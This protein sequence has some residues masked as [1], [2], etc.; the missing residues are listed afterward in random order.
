VDVGQYKILECDIDNQCCWIMLA[1]HGIFSA[2]ILFS[3]DMNISQTSPVSHGT[4]LDQIWHAAAGDRRYL[5]VLQCLGSGSLDSIFA[6]SD[7]ALASVGAAGLALQ[8]LLQTAGVAQPG[9][10]QVVADRRLASLWFSGTIRPQGWQ[11]PSLWDAV[12]G[13][14][15]TA[16]GWIRL[17]TNAPHHRAAALA[18]LGVAADKAA[19][20]QAVQDWSAEA[21]EAAVVAQGGCAAAMRTMAQWQVHPQG[22]AVN[23]EPLLHWTVAA[24]SAVPDWQ[25]LPQRPLQGIRVLDLTRVLAGPTAT[26]FLAGFGAQVLRIDPPGWDEPGVVPDMTVGKQCARVDLHTAAGRATFGELLAQAD[27]LVHGYRA[28][29]LDGLGFDAGQRRR[30]NPGLVDVSLNA[31]GWSGPW[32]HRRGFDSLV[33]MSSGIAEAGMQQL[34]RTRPTPLPVQALDYACG[35]LLATAAIRGLTQ[36]LQSG[37]GVTAQT[38]LARMAQLLVS[39]SG[40][41]VA[42]QGPLVPESA[43]DLA[44][45][46]EATHWGA[47]QRLR[48]PV[49]LQ[50]AAGEIEA[51]MAWQLPAMPLGSAAPRW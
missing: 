11:L 18:V 48:G 4:F 46:I 42:Q 16:D 22:A 7:L 10:L 12:A 21:L 8:E 23:R 2:F 28:G 51:A 27:V 6:V 20:A 19:V 32:Q 49:W 41:G 29:A 9:S 39:V 47:A 35:Y 50:N 25:P 5:Q 30:L 43:A 15:Q 40:S 1:C 34:G 38:S 36:R 17:H 14:Y 31:Y 24:A 13:D 45:T 37:C 3:D 33:Q 26:R 44:P